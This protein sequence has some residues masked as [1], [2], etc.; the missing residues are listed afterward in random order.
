[1]K[2]LS[3]LMPSRILLAAGFAA[4]VALGSGHAKA[5]DLAQGSAA[6]RPAPVETTPLPPALPKP[7][8]PAPSPP[9]DTGAQSGGVTLTQE[10]T[11]PGAATAQTPAL[12]ATTARPTLVPAPGDPLDVAEVTLP[13]K[14]AAALSGQSSWDE[15]FENLKN[16]FAKIES[17]LARAG[18][19][20]AG[21]PIS[22]FLE[23][24]DAG[25]R[26]E[27]MVPVEGAPEG[28]A[29]LTSEIRFGRTPEGKAYHFV[30]KGPYDDIDSTYETITAYLDAKGIIAKDVFIEEYVTDFT[31]S[32]DDSLEIN[33][34]VQPR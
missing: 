24:D 9:P 1:M 12:P 3:D 28:R 4:I 5:Q 29:D 22:V 30:H 8:S 20:P 31:D 33:I 13:A 23:T 10:P 14:P 7:S 32:A 2:K 16:A 15:G 17:E 6:P 18:L 11:G 21:R 34:F 26:Y 27:A 19:R 25:F